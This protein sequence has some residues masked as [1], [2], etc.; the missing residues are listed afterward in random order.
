V[1]ITRR[2]TI[3]RKLTEFE[4]RQVRQLVDGDDF[5]LISLPK[6]L[7]KWEGDR[8]ARVPV[9]MVSSL[10]MDAIEYTILALA[11]QIVAKEKAKEEL[12]VV[13]AMSEEEALRQ[14]GHLGDGK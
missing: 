4:L 8:L 12:E 10:D 14:C 11:T 2:K 9:G 1:G 5:I 13:E 6:D 7:E 3:V